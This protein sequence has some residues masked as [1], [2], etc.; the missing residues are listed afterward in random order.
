MRNVLLGVFFFVVILTPI[1]LLGAEHYSVQVGS[2]KEF[3]NAAKVISSPELSSLECE[4]NENGDLY[5][6]TCGD[7]SD[8]VT[9]QSATETIKELGYNNAFFVVKN[10]VAPSNQTTKTGREAPPE[11]SKPVKG[12][13]F[14]RKGGYFHPFLALGLYYT[15]NVFNTPDNEKSDIMLVITPGVWVSVP[16]VKHKLLKI[17]T[18]NIS[19][20]GLELSLFREKFPRRYQTYLLYRADIEQFKKYSSENTISHKLDG[21]FQYNFRGGL[22]IDLI[23]QFRK[24]HDLRGTGITSELDKFNSNLFNLVFTYDMSEKFKLRGEY[25]NFFIDYDAERNNFRDRVD[26]GINAYLYYHI[27]PK[28]SIFVEYEYL[29]INYDTSIVDNSNEHHLF[30]GLQWD[31]TAKSKGRVK[32]GYGEKNFSKGGSAKNFIFEIQIDH[33]FTP[34]TSFK[35]AG[36]RRTNETTISVSDYIFTNAIKAEL[37]HRFTGKISGAF[38]LG[39]RND[40]Y[41]GNITI[42]DVTDERDDD[43]YT[44]MIAFQYEY[45]DYIKADLGYLYTRRDSNFNDFD[46]TNNTFFFRVTGTL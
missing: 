19:P 46:F 43:I 16:R 32:A 6:V 17:R 13:I 14:E 45:K 40:L 10:V 42:G 11:G 34:K 24:S 28:S 37:L 44:A 38:D 22:S 4:I 20:G 33:R 7:F 21:L 29:D 27:R 30:G 12:E 3:E 31:I 36:T 15:D 18:E 2:F 23:D 8:S 25:S 5:R 26:N 39:Y 35:V 41:K 1:P 9:A